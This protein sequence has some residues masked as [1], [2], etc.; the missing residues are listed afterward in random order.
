MNPIRNS[1]KAIIV[2]NNCILL[3]RNFDEDGNWYLLP[4]GGQNSGETIHQALHREVYEET[5]ASITIGSLLLVR[6]YIAKNHEFA[7]VEPE[8][9]QIE[10][11]FS[12]CLK[13]DYS[14]EMGITPDIYQ[15]GVE[16]IELSRLSEFRIYPSVLK[17]LL[18][19]G[20]PID[21]EIY[22]GDVN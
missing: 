2:K 21:S 12:C 10:Y 20:I 18:K 16:W 22:I 4:G 17:K 5:K 3:T 14:P 6:E 8:V 15:N 7:D 19:N 13:G 9:H 11:M 1:A